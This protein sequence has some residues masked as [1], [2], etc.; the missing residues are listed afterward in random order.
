MTAANLHATS[1]VCVGR[2]GALLVVGQLVQGRQLLKT[3]RRSQPPRPVDTALSWTVPV[4]TG[5][6]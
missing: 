1:L 3:L 4:S 5:C 2:A 6:A